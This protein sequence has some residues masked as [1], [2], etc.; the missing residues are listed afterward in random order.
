MCCLFSTFLEQ[1]VSS[2]R[3]KVEAGKCRLSGSRNTPVETASASP[4]GSGHCCNSPSGRRYFPERSQRS[5][6]TQHPGFHLSCVRRN[7]PGARC[8][9]NFPSWTW[10]AE[11]HCPSAFGGKRSW[12]SG[13]PSLN[14]QWWYYPAGCR[15]PA[16]EHPPFPTRRTPPERGS[17][18]R[19]E[20]LWSWHPEWLTSNISH[21]CRTDR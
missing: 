1:T 9:S 10:I 12:C 5:R 2:Q 15:S 14:G 3:C 16:P 7:F 19:P 21:L 18:G 17:A 20:S 13:I 11:I 6:R 4:T 8:P